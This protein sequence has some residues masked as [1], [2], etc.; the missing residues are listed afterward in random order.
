[1]FLPGFSC[2]K[3]LITEQSPPKPQ[4]PTPIFSTVRYTPKVIINKDTNIWHHA[5]LHGATDTL[6]CLPLQYTPMRLLENKPTGDTSID[7][8]G[9]TQL[10][11]FVLL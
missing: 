4:P 7:K 5:Q 1:M 6:T 11:I 8:C 9:Q 10:L 3:H 2:P